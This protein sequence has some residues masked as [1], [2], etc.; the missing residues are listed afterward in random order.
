[1]STYSLGSAS[2]VNMSRPPVRLSQQAVNEIRPGMDGHAIFL[3]G[4][5]GDEF[6][7]RTF[8]NVA[9]SAVESTAHAYRALRNTLV[10]LVYNGVAEA[11]LY[12][13]LDVQIVDASRTVVGIGGLATPSTGKVEASWRLICTN[14]DVPPPP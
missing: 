4:Q 13:V 8:A 2:F 9:S 5:R 7:V 3:T 6:E 11:K 1:M 12:Q 10:T 14:V